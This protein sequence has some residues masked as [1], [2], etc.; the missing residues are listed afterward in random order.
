[1]AS[2]EK[3]IFIEEGELHICDHTANPG[4]LG[5]GCSAL[6][7]HDFGKQVLILILYSGLFSRGPIFADCCYQRNSLVQFSWI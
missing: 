6:I 5:M 2:Q 1:M 7:T 3:C 4:L